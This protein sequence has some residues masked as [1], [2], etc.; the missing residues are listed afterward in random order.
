MWALNN[1]IAAELSAPLPQVFNDTKYCFWK[2]SLMGKLSK[3]NS[4][5]QNKLKK[6]KQPTP[7]DL[8]DEVPTWI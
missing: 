1:G 6:K 7:L 8:A 5:N 2:E 3:T 4:T